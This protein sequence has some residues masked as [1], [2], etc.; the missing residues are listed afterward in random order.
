MS[1]L[2]D[3]KQRIQLLEQQLADAQLDGRRASRYSTD[4]RLNR[5]LGDPL[6]L[7][8]FP[9]L[10]IVLSRERRILYVNR[11]EG[12]DEP[13]DYI[14]AD[15]LVS[16]HDD[17]RERY[18]TVFEECWR[19]GE[20]A[21]IEIRSVNGYWWDSRLVPVRDAGEVVFMLVSSTDVTQRKAQE[22]ALRE[23]ESS[24]RL[25]LLASGVGTWT[26]WLRTN[27]LY[28]DEA[29]CEIF[30]VEPKD[31][32][33]SREEYLD[34]VHPEDRAEVIEQIK[35]YVDTG[36]YDGMAYR[37]IRPNG[38]LRHV[39]AKGVAQ[40]DEQGELEALRG[41]VLD[42]TER[43]ELEASLAQA[44]RMQAV[45][46][47]TA[48]IAHNLNNA[49]SVILPNVAECRELA[50]DLVA[51]RLADVE[52][53]SMRAAE[54]V[55]QLML[56]AR[57]QDNASR[58]SFDLTEA[59][60]RI[61][62]MC[63][64]TFDRK[65]QIELLTAEIPAALGNSGQIEQVLLNVCLNARDALLES[66]GA[67][68]CLRVEFSEPAPGR[69]CVSLTDNGVGMTEAVRVRI[70]EPFFTTKEM[71]R[72]TGLGLSSAYAIVTDHG[73]TIECSSRLGEGTRFEIELPAAPAAQPEF[74][75]TKRAPLPVGTE[76]ILVVDDELAVRQVLR[77][78][79]ERSGFRVI[80][81]EDGAQ[82]LAALER[83]P[84]ADALLIDRSMPGMSGEQVIDRLG[85][86]GIRL[87]VLVLSGHSSVK[88]TDPNV[89]A[90]L[91]KPITR[92]ALIFEVRRALDRYLPRVR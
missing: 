84:R 70:F 28:W 37:I 78:M 65:L 30:G 59:A 24:A 73:G 49:L 91:S 54:M 38:S 39:I 7:A 27:E 10:I 6:V 26:W 34:L 53:A 12:D 76:T 25:S 81:C 85:Q 4:P 40:F 1:E 79:L 36:V 56:F 33:R 72:G 55:R 68:P 19:L 14:G 61:V 87:P 43:K 2:H 74:V 8:T 58:S 15:C 77:R 52:H 42:V 69:V 45:G 64:S 46:R 83:Q 50:A 67:E 88:L 47:L 80:E 11:A 44:Q 60:R 66:E 71:G 63:R 48:G 62:D 35:L 23:R 20:P 86:I 13:A 51:E 75:A 92:E 9:H 21:S 16:I 82:A 41:G 22:Q 5:L 31:A 89:M 3:A 57:P 90:V 18:R 17:D 32:P 29:L